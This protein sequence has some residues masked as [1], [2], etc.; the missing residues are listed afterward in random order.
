MQSDLPIIKQGLNDRIVEVCAQMLPRGRRE[1]ALWVSCNPRVAD[2]DKKLPALKVGLVR[3]K[4]AWRCWRHG[5]KGDVIALIAFAL[6]TDT[7]GALQWARDFLGLRK[8]NREEREAL[9]R[10]AAQRQKIDAEKAA[11]A[12]VFKLQKADELFRQADEMGKGGGAEAHARAY[13]AARQC[14]LE[15]VAALNPF[16]FRFSGAT[17]WWKGAEWQNDN[18]RRFRT[19]EGPKFPAIHTAMRSAT[20]VVTCCHVTF[21]DPLRPE[22]APVAP[23]KLMFG[24]ALGAVI[25]LSMGPS[26]RPF[27]AVNETAAPVIICEGI[28]TGLSIA[29]SVPDARVWAG[30]SLA[31]MAGAPVHL[32]CVSDITVAR[33]NNTGNAQAQAQLMAALDRLADAGKPLVVMESHVGDDFNDLKRGET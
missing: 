5:D 2:D 1:G 29:G 14:P 12:R 13:L 26:G 6:G 15:D 17:E 11:K 7:K 32:S 27:W 25:E 8:M 10:E 21:L 28:E 31:G 23:P 20:G 3:D 30:G 16:T 22:K 9:R 4:G 19:K 33:D 18:G 24:E